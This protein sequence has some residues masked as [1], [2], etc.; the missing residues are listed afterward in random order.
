MAG[1]RPRK[2]A[3]GNPPSFKIRRR[4]VRRILE[5]DDADVPLREAD[6]FDGAAGPDCVALERPEAVAFPAPEIP[7]TIFRG[8]L[9]P[10]PAHD[11]ERGRF[12]GP[13]VRDR[14]AESD[15]VSLGNYRDISG[16]TL[17]RHS[18]CFALPLYGRD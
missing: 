6:A 8:A 9:H 15:D 16:D 11:H 10:R 3:A 5:D 17:A 18:L 14:R 4:S 12:F 7:R 1:E 13:V 2:D